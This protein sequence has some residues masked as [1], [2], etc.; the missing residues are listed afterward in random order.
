[1]KEL[2]SCIE[3]LPLTFF[4]YVLAKCEADPGAF[5]AMYGSAMENA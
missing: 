4:A 1:M 2:I 3:S 5:A